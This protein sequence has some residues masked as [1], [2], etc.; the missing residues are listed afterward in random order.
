MDGD[1]AP[2]AEICDVAD[3][4]GAMTYLDEVHAVG[5]YGPRGGGLSERDGVAH[6]LTVIEGTL[7]K[8]FG[9][10]G[11]YIAGSRALID[12]LT[13]RARSFIFSTAPAP[14]VAAASRA[15]L[16]IVASEE[17][18]RLRARLRENLKSLASGLKL[19]PSQSAII[20]I[21]LGSGERAMRESARLLEAGLL[22]P[23][24]RYP[25]VPRQSARLRVTLSAS[26]GP[27][28]IRTLAT[29]LQAGVKN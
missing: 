28:E 6:R 9:V 11:G 10:V 25:T 18:D 27:E 3:E 24:I 1:I 19:H 23:A 8:A 7:A 17:G 26:H 16:R 15:S 20:P 5:L 2:I 12:V 21:I 22:V 13:N 4:F 14:A 29:V